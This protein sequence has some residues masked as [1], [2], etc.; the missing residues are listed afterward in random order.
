MIID[1]DWK[2]YARIHSK[3]QKCRE[4]PVFLQTHTHK[5]ACF[6]GPAST[7]EQ[8]GGITID[9]EG[10]EARKCSGSSERKGGLCDERYVERLNE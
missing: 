2:D 4:I 10:E 3:Y 1:A 8:S 7:D 5:Q 6:S 9:G